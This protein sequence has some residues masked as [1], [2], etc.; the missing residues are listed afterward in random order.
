MELA[1]L[2]KL[3]SR[4][5]VVYVEAGGKVE[6]KMFLCSAEEGRATSDK[7]NNPVR[8][9]K[10]SMRTYRL[11]TLTTHTHTHTHTR[12]H[13]FCCL[14]WGGGG[15]RACMHRCVHSFHWFSVI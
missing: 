4:S 5:I 12:T 13:T 14:T 2:S 6:E 1:A 3:Y 9:T 11:C 15:V 8:T 10:L 7:L